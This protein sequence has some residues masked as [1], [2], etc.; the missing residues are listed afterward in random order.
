MEVFCQMYINEFLFN[1]VSTLGRESFLD[2][3]P[4][5]RCADGGID[6]K[7]SIIGK[8]FPHRPWDKHGSFVSESRNYI[9]KPL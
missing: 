2:Y 7:R 6:R 4:E 9:A 5:Y 8:S 3:F 1:G